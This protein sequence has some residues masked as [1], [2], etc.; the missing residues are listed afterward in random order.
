MSSA[1]CAVI[2]FSPKVG[3]AELGYDVLMVDT[4]FDYRNPHHF[5]RYFRASHD[6]E[7]YR[8]P[9]GKGG[10]YRVLEMA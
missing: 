6:P 10:A 5:R 1:K 9:S 2:L 3:R 4:S 7:N 8:E